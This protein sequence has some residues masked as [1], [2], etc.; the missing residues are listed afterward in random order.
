MLETWACFIFFFDIL[1]KQKRSIAALLLSTVFS[2][3]AFFN[4]S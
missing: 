2:F 3:G 1:D 4:A